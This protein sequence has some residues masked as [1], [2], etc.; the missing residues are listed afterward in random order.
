MTISREPRP[1]F[2]A[3]MLDDTVGAAAEFRA[4]RRVEKKR[5]AAGVSRPVA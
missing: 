1:E 4:E 5:G 3:F 2:G